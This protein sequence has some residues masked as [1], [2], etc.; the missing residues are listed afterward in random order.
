MECQCVLF[1]WEVFFPGEQNDPIPT[2]GT[3]LLE[4]APV[5][6]GNVDCHLGTC[7][8]LFDS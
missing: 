2:Q 6:A 7:P 4:S 3:H 8:L 1:Q 5:V